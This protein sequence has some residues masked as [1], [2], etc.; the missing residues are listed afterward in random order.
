LRVEPPKDKTVYGFPL[1]TD[2][3]MPKDKWEFRTPQR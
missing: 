3:D 2:P 1:K